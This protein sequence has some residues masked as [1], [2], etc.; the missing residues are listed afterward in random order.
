[1]LEISK[2]WHLVVADFN[3]DGCDDILVGG[4]DPDDR[5]WYRTLTGYQPGPFVFDV[6]DRH[7]CDAAVRSRDAS[8]GKARIAIEAKRRPTSRPAPGFSMTWLCR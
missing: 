3:G 4:H 1:M 5:I 8:W 6:V 2:A 7:A